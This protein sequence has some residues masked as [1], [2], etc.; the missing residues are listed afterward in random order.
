[1]IYDAGR[2]YAV[3]VEAQAGTS[4]HRARSPDFQAI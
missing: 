4:V 1:M 3:D 2:A